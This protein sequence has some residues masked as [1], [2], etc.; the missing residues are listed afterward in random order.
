MDKIVQKSRK[1]MNKNCE[2]YRKA[3]R[4]FKDY[5]QDYVDGMTIL[6]VKCQE[7]EERR[8]IA[9]KSAMF[10]VHKALNMIQ[11]QR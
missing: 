6:F 8:L 5:H 3:F 2:K 7:Y 4:N 11:D 1:E 9:F 10:S